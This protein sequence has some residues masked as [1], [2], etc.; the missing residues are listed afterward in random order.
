MVTPPPNNQNKRQTWMQPPAICQALEPIDKIT[1]QRNAGHVWTGEVLE[2]EGSRSG[3]VYRSVFKHLDPTTTLPIEVACA[4]T[5]ALLGNDVPPPCLVWANTAELPQAPEGMKGNVVLMFGC[6]YINQDSFYEQLAAQDSD[7]ALHAAVWGSFC[8]DAPRAAKGAALDELISNFDRHLRNL[9]F[10]GKR[11]WLIDHDM[12]LMQTHGKVL[13]QMP[14]D[15]K[16]FKNEI[17]LELLDRRAQDH[18]MHVAARRSADKL[19]EVAAL[20]AMAGLWSHEQHLVQDVWK[21]VA[22]LLALLAR[23]MPMLEDMIGARIGNP[24]ETPTLWNP[25]TAP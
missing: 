24:A 19:Q 3:D 7:T 12:S 5:G 4:L 22:A 16:S 14:A 17:A 23:R 11:W 10:D 8:D 15:F 6:A 9:R 25:P 20:A 21:R 18:D 1:G 13:A 2:L